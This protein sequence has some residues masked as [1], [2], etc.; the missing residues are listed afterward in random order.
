VA[1]LRVSRWLRRI[2]T[3]A[4]ALGMG[5]VHCSISQRRNS[6]TPYATICDSRPFPPAAEVGVYAPGVARLRM[7]GMR[8][9]RRIGSD[10]EALGM[11]CV[12][13]SISQRS[14][15]QYSDHHDDL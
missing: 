6:I 9:L 2:G 7:S 10:T 3:N 1:R 13:C 12:H 4:G 8:W 5:R 11:G 15:A 14:Q